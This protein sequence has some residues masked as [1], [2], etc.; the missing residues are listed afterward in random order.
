MFALSFFML[1]SKDADLHIL[2]EAELGTV[3]FFAS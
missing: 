3:P 2:A 1:S